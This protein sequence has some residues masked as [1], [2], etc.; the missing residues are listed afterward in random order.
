[1]RNFIEKLDEDIGRDALELAEEDWAQ[2]SAA[3]IRQRNLIEGRLKKKTK[4]VVIK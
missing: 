1:M 3:L 2:M 4:L